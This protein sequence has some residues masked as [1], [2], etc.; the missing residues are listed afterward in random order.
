MRHKDNLHLL[1]FGILRR[2]AL[3]GELL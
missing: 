3:Q 2:R 1:T